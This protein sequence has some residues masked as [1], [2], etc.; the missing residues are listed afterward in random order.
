MKKT[1]NNR[2]KKNK[3]K[4]QKFYWLLGQSILPQN[5]MIERT[6]Q[7]TCQI[8]NSSIKS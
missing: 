6:Y 3:D 1:V 5:Y 7:I 8:S 2:Q 4:K